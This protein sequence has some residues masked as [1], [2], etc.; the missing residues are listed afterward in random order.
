M[1]A[2]PTTGSDAQRRTVTTDD[3]LSLSV[4]IQGGQNAE[5]TVIFVHGFWLSHRDWDDQIRCLAKMDSSLR[6]VTFDLRGH[7][8]SSRATSATYTID[9]LGSDLAAVIDDISP[10]GPIVLI[11]HSMGAMAILAYAAAHPEMIGTRV[12]AGALLSTAAQG[13]TQAGAIPRSVV[14]GL[15]LLAQ[16]AP[17][18]AQRA[19]E[20]ATRTGSTFHG[21]IRGNVLLGRFFTRFTVGS[22]ERIGLESLCG[23]FHSLSSHDHTAA[24]P[25]LASI[26]VL[27]LCGTYDLATPLRNSVTIANALPHAELLCVPRA[28][29][30][31]HHEQPRVVADAIAGLI[32]RGLDD[33]QQLPTAPRSN[34]GNAL[35]T[36]AV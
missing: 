17:G 4:H 29:H 25:V 19:A 7:G 16:K 10:Q 18:A 13:L 20:I 14:A 21:T 26:P 22:D 8:C 33:A 31:V 34:C 32:R 6:I 36:S 2:V 5:A 35:I 11:G 28:G 24:L 9:Q 15:D 27:V 3:G 12:V 30:L 23:F 1:S